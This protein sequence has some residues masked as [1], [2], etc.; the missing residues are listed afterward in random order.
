MY[1][2]ISVLSN[3][4]KCT[5]IMCLVELLKQ[6]VSAG[7]VAV[8]ELLQ[9]TCSLFPLINCYI[10]TAARMGPFGEGKELSPLIFPQITGRTL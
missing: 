9:L 2:S 4:V 10:V 7:R 1:P 5:H 6:F 3:F 8:T